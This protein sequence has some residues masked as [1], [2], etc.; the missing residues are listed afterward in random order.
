MLMP[1]KVKFRKSHRGRMTGMS[2]GAR[3]VD[4]GQF[5]LEAMEP[6]WITSQ[7]IEALRVSV[8]RKLK[9]GGQFFLRM[10]PD[11]PVSKKP[12]ETRMGKGKGNPEFWVAVV[13]RGRV[14]CELGGVD[15]VS[16]KEIFKQAGFKLPI[17][18]KFVRKE[19]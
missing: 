1:K 6:A 13:K 15:E 4:F 7:Q 10:F 2:K 18:T 11:K 5:G 14:I 8:S 17:K 16:A 3:T 12:L 9:K 19:V